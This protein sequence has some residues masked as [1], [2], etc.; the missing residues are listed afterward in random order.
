MKSQTP[1]SPLLVEGKSWLARRNKSPRRIAKK[2]H[3]SRTGGATMKM[4]PT[5]F[6]SIG[7]ARLFVADADDEPKTPPL[8]TPPPKIP[9]PKTPPHAAHSETAIIVGAVCGVVGLVLLVVLGEYAASWW[10]KTR[11][12]PGSEQ[13]PHE[14]QGRDVGGSVR[15]EVVKWSELQAQSASERPMYELGPPRVWSAQIH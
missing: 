10:R 3:H 6:S 4:P 13:P 9:P 8:K 15:R 14:M 1:S 5:N 12:H 7:L 2:I 11:I